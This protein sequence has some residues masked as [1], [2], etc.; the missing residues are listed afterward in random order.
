MYAKLIRHVSGSTPPFRGKQRLIN[1]LCPRDPS[2]QFEVFG[3]SMALDLR[4]GIQRDV[5]LERYEREETALVRRVLQPG[6][7]V[8]DAGANIGYY[9]ALAASIVGVRGKVFAFEPSPYAYGRLAEWIKENGVRQVSA[10]NMGLGDHDGT[11]DLY[12][13]PE[14][15]GNHDPSVVEYCSGMNRIT[16]PIRRL[17]SVIE[18][19]DLL[20]VDFMKV[21][22]EGYEPMLLRG[23]E[24]FLRSG[25]VRYL[26]CEFN[27]KLLSMAGSSSNELETYLVNLGFRVIEVKR[28]GSVFSNMLLAHSG[29]T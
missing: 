12:V 5:F 6:M 21:D 7:T 24:R 8:I 29:R 28:S 15:Y 9:T 18:E 22:V 13:P 4:D 26:L 20:C 16:V 23:C 14:S 11:L 2:R 19:F 10:F 27:D 17:E 3:F 1:L 25:K